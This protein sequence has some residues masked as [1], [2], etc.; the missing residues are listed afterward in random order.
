MIYKPICLAYN[1]KADTVVDTSS[2]LY[3][4]NFEI[5][6]SSADV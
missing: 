4:T 1:G 3:D 2:V 6:P 5:G